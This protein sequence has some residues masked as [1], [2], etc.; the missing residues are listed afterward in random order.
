MSTTFGVIVNGEKE[1]VEIAFRSG[2]EIVWKNPL[3]KLLSNDTAVIPL[4]NSAQG[5]K[6]I[7]DIKKAMVSTIDVKSVVRDTM[8]NMFYNMGAGEPTNLDEIKEW[9]EKDLRDL[10]FTEV[11]DSVGSNSVLQSYINWIETRK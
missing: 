11:I 2:G 7:R 9:I 8:D 1:P 5:I 4:D 3:G 6:T 10:L